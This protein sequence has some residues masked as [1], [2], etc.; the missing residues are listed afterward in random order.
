MPQPHEDLQ[1]ICSRLNEPLNG[2]PH[3]NCN[4]FQS[5][6][7]L[8][9][10]W[11]RKTLR[12]SLPRWMARRSPDF[13][14]RCTSLDIRLCSST[15]TGSRSNMQV[16][17][18]RL[19]SVWPDWAIYC[20]LGNF[21]KPWQDIFFP[22]CPHFQSIFVKVSKSFIILV[23]SF[24]GNFYWHLAIFTGHT[25]HHIK[26]ASIIAQAEYFANALMCPATKL[27]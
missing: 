20:T 2:M 13:W 16:R 26:R 21:S 4:P 15:G 18:L 5:S 6:S 3:P 24:L 17:K 12:S 25:V 9:R 1:Q 23:K 10:S 14:R 7:R 22:N 11:R 19:W 27:L 8:P